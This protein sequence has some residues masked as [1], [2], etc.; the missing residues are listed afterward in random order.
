MTNK[1]IERTI[2]QDAKNPI[3]IN[4]TPVAATVANKSPFVSPMDAVKQRLSGSLATSV[5]SS[6]SSFTARVKSFFVQNEY[7]KALTTAGVTSFSVATVMYAFE[8]RQAEKQLGIAVSLMNPA[9]MNYRALNI[10]FRG[11]VKANQGSLM[12]NAAITQKDSISSNVDSMLGEKGKENKPNTG[13][14]NKYAVTGI[15]AAG[16][17][18]LD[19]GFTH[20]LA[21]VRALLAAQKDYPLLSVADRFKLYKGNIAPFGTKSYLPSLAS[22]ASKA[23]KESITEK[24]RFAKSGVALRGSRNY[25]SSLAC[26][27][28]TTVLSDWINPYI[29][30]DAHPFM[31]NAAT[32]IIA[33][34]VIAPPSNVFD[35]LYR[36]QVVQFDFKTFTAPKIRDV[37][38][39]T[40]KKEGPKALFCGTGWG[41]FNGILAFTT[42]NYISDLLENYVFSTEK[43]KQPQV[44]QARNGFFNQAAKPQQRPEVDM[45]AV[46]T[47]EPQQQESPTPKV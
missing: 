41:A 42:I 7:G 3:I 15:S 4:Q 36:R 34:T 35:V 11:Y 25:L 10:I 43:A 45:K 2:E 5:G 19:M 12:K 44:S 46:A 39:S 27:G 14:I 28:T 47:V 8:L 37:L 1:K 13:N 21:N 31:H 40:V 24:A 30:R 20:Y 16:V 29:S 6:N 26:I 18:L 38:I 22:V 32:S 23:V 17:T 9:T 33:G